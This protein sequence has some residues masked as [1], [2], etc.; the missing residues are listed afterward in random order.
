MSLHKPTQMPHCSSKVI[1]GQ[2][3]RPYLSDSMDAISWLAGH[4]EILAN[5]LLWQASDSRPA[6]VCLWIRALAALCP[7]GM[8]LE[9]SSVTQTFLQLYKKLPHVEHLAHPLNCMQLQTQHSAQ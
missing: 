5:L 4:P 1:T 2:Q 6:D 7:D 8:L 3:E 9:Q